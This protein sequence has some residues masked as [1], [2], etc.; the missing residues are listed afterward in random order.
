M[1][2]TLVMVVVLNLISRALKAAAS[3]LDNHDSK[4]SEAS[5]MQSPPEAL[6]GAL[7]IAIDLAFGIP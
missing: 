2:V 1:V 4:R 5:S 6:L 7:D 3:S